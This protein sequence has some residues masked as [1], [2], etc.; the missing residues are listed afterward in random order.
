MLE[1][2]QFIY[3]VRRSDTLAR[4]ATP[5]KRAALQARRFRHLLK[6]AVAA[7]PFYRS[8]F[9]GIDLDRCAL[10]ELPIL[11]KSDFIAHFD[12][13]VTDRAIQKEDVRQFMNDPANL[14]K[15]YLGKYVVCHTSGSQGE[16]ALLVQ[17]AQDVMKTF[18]M[19][20]AR[21]HSMPKTW[22]TLWQKLTGPKLR[23]SVV[24]FRKSFF[25]SG[26]AFENIPTPMRKL[27]SIQRLNINDPL[28]INLRELNT[29]QPNIITAYA[30]VL[31]NL[32]RAEL[33]GRLHLRKAQ[34][35]QHVTS[36][37]EPI[38]DM[39]R[40]YINRAW[41][42]PIANH[43]AMGECLGLTLGC[44]QGY[45]AHLNPD[46]AILEVVDR[47]YR[48]VEAGKP[49][50][51]VLVT[52]LLNLTQP[53]IRYE[54]DDVI[55][56]SPTPCPCGNALPL[57]S[58]IAGRSNDRLWYRRGNHYQEVAMFL[59]KKMAAGNPAVAEFQV[60]QP[61]RNRFILRVEPRP[62][63]HI[64]TEEMEQIIDR[65]LG[66]EKLLGVLE[67]D[68]EVVDHIGPDPRTGKL[69]R[70]ISQV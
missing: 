6:T 44:P 9:A 24:L 21:G 18:A 35:L 38:S 28:D 53:L 13:I 31:E 61:E 68:V 10:S 22:K 40:D 54:V 17:T 50:D 23:W 37:S 25:P 52:N 43:Y 48:P 65:E 67:V 12:D 62:D 14:G 58:D 49:G 27:A 4:L 42:V 47:H 39:A 64:S 32:A 29:F 66:F 16:S 36:I 56:M 34:C 26:A 5:Q 51:K 19:Q 45:G 33:Q 1:T 59:F 30:H 11:K 8:R 69:R 60:H 3:H 46:L 15:K 20:A 41:G 2:L 70:V 55:T 7:S 57:I 63:M